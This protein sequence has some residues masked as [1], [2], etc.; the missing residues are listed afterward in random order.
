MLQKNVFGQKNFWISC[1]GSKVPF[2]QFFIF[3]KMALLN[4]LHEIQKFF[5][6]KAFFWIIMKM[7][8]RNF[9][10]NMSQGLPNPG[11]MQEKVLKGDFLRCPTMKFFLTH[12]SDST[13]QECMVFARIGHGSCYHHWN[14]VFAGVLQDGTANPAQPEKLIY[15]SLVRTQ[16]AIWELNF[17]NIFAMCFAIRQ[18]K[19]LD[20]FR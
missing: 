20:E 14:E 9:F 4:P 3:A 15:L 16:K 6:P 2:W 8:L 12:F 18:G 1:T 11:F 7:G 17:L 19:Q 5:W 10:R 13:H